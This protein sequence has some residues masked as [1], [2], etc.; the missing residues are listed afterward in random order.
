MLQVPLVK[1]TIFVLKTLSIPAEGQTLPPLHGCHNL[2]T[3]Q[4]VPGPTYVTDLVSKCNWSN[5]VILI[6]FKF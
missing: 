2:A 5:A 4:V 1:G 3:K 6:P